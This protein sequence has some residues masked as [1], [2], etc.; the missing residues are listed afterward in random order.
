MVF[1]G[2]GGGTPGAA[3]IPWASA[4][5]ALCAEGDI[6]DTVATLAA[7]VDSRRLAAVPAALAELADAM[8]A[9]RYC[10]LV[11]KQKFS[12]RHMYLPTPESIYYFNKGVSHKALIALVPSAI[13]SLSVA[14]LPMFADIKDFGWFIGAP[15]AGL[16]YYV[17]AK[18]KVVILPDAESA[19]L[20]EQA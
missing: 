18:N 15:L 3:E 2:A 11:R 16:I 12:I 8:R 13:V 10:V 1:L 5:D 14:L 17:V 6:F 9:A 4:V 20:H 7:L 19:P